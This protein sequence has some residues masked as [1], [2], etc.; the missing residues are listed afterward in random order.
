MTYEIRVHRST[1]PWIGKNALR[2]VR[3]PGF[4]AANRFPEFPAAHTCH[5]CARPKWFGVWTL[6]RLQCWPFTCTSSDVS[7][8][9]RVCSRVERA[10]S[11]MSDDADEIHSAPHL[12]SKVW[13]SFGFFST[14]SEFWT[15]FL[16]LIGNFFC[17]ITTFIF[18]IKP[19]ISLCCLNW[20]WMFSRPGVLSLGH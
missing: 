2:T 3:W 1:E 16:P 8:V 17:F 4:T 13:K 9:E 20:C 10:G 19:Q 14:N 7:C 12:K 11:N 15:E 18:D 6:M 5:C